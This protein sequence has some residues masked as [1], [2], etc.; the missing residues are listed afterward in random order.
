[1]KAARK[2]FLMVAVLPWR[3]TAIGA[4]GEQRAGECN[5]LR[6]AGGAARA[7]SRPPLWYTK[8]HSILNP[9][10]CPLRIYGIHIESV[11]FRDCSNRVPFSFPFLVQFRAGD[12]IDEQL[13]E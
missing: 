7:S 10:S 8:P 12:S 9:N 11:E 4:S 3:W 6:A 2:N 1:M 13:I 5:P